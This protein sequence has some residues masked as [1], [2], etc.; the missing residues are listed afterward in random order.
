MPVLL[1]H[2]LFLSIVDAQ[3]QTPYL[4]FLGE[5]LMNL[6]YVDFSLVGHLD[7]GKSVQCHTN[8]QDCCSKE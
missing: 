5:N 6:S 2:L 4:T 3:S 7:G 8:L 1:I